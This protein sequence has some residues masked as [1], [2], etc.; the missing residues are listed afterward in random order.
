MNTG[1]SRHAGISQRKRPRHPLAVA[2]ACRRI[3]P[4]VV[5][6]IFASAAFAQPTNLAANVGT[7]PDVGVSVLRVFGALALVLA[8]FLGGIWLFRNWQRLMLQK[9]GMPKLNILEVRSLGN[10][11][12]LYVVGYQEQRLL[13]ATSPAGVS[14]LSHL[15]AAENN[16]ASPAPASNALSF[17][18]ALQHVL[19]RK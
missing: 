16:G 17:A 9:G 11:Y 1:Y 14:L 7:L 8:L 2:N 4:G 18:Q 19:S 15:P 13:V 5:S 10:R 6:C 12:A 3:A